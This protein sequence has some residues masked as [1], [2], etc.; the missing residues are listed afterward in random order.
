MEKDKDLDKIIDK[1]QKLLAMAADTSTPNEALIAARR[2]RALMDKYQIT[3]GDIESK[4]G[5]QFLETCIH[6]KYKRGVRWMMFLAKAAG[7]LNDCMPLV[8][9]NVENNVDYLFQGFRADAIVAKL[10]MEYFMQS[11]QRALKQQSLSGKTENNFFRL[12]FASMI[13][14]RVQE[15]MIERQKSFVSPQGTALVPLKMA[16]VKDYFGM[17]DSRKFPT[18]DPASKEEQAAFVAGIEEA[19]KL[20]LEKQVEEK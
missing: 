19:N 3:V 5:S 6:T 13:D 10:T 7:N 8:A 20:S 4:K 1:I 18:R 12:G 2:A 16:M 9:R 11:C 15:V 14:R 17:A